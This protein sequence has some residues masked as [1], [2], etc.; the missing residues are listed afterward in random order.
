M[1]ILLYFNSSDSYCSENNKC[2]EEQSKLIKQTVN[3]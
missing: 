1:W 3:V 2:S